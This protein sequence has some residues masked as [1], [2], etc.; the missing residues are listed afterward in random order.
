[1]ANGELGVG[2]ADLREHAVSE[3]YRER[4]SAANADGTLPLVAPS[5]NPLVAPSRNPVY[6]AATLVQAVGRR[7]WR[8]E[9]AYGMG[10]LRRHLF[11]SAAERGRSERRSLPYLGITTLMLNEERDLREWIEF[12]RLQGVERFYLYDNGSTDDTEEVV[13]P[14][15]EEGIAEV[16]PWPHRGAQR[17]AI[18]DSFARHRDDVRWLACIDVDEFLFC[19]T[20][21]RVCDVLREFEGYP[22]VA[23]H[24][25]VFGTS[26]VARRPPDA[27][28]LPTFTRRS[29]DFSSTSVNRHIKSIVDPWCALDLVPP[30]PH[31]RPYRVG[32]AVNEIGCPVIGPLPWPIRCERL[33]INHYWPKSKAECLKKVALSTSSALI[34]TDYKPHYMEQY[35]DPA[36]NAVEEHAI[37]RARERLAGGG[38]LR[39]RTRRRARTTRAASD[40]ALE[41]AVLLGRALRRYGVRRLLRDGPRRIAADPLRLLS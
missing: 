3:R 40:L 10:E 21:E 31:H 33:R 34:G 39:A 4:E 22:A 30:D 2:E 11:P 36:L 41:L 24:W 20:G 17:A 26:D 25:H 15:V 8:P 32:F 23:V 5:R 9:L 35:A 19:P 16:V 6:V 13:R 29:D 12:H 14:Y 28:V 7:R 27:E 37:L 1:V 38:T 18:A